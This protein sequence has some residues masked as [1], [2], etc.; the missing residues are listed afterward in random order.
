MVER[1]LDQ[2]NQNVSS[3]T[4]WRYG[5][6]GSLSVKVGGERAVLVSNDSDIAEALRM[7]KAQ[8]N[9]KVGL[10]FPN[11]DPKRRH[12]HQLTLYADF[13]KSIRHSALANSQL[14]HKIPGTEIVKPA[15]WD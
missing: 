14:P 4:D 2:R 9:R 11:T 7:I 15:L 13:V 1:L 3:G 5:K 10:I 8:H 6:K 12:S